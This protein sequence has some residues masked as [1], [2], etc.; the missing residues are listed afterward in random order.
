MGIAAWSEFLVHYGWR[1]GFPATT[2]N[3]MVF[4]AGNIL[5]HG[6]VNGVVRSFLGIF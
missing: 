2:E 4:I 3:S 1:G 6:G 5:T